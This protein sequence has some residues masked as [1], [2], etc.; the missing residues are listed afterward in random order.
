MDRMLGS[1]HSII[2]ALRQR[3]CYSKEKNKIP[4]TIPRETGNL[5]DERIVEKTKEFQALQA[6]LRHWQE[7]QTQIDKMCTSLQEMKRPSFYNR[8][9]A[10]FRDR[11]FDMFIFVPVIVI[12]ICLVLLPFMIGGAVAI[13]CITPERPK[14]TTQEAA[15]DLRMARLR[16]ALRL[17]KEAREAGLASTKQASSNVVDNKGGA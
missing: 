9:K 13:L 14:A 17:K 11:L 6:K 15:F 5:A 8:H 1:D 16:E 12:G 10:N 7:Y 3:R 4:D 2:K